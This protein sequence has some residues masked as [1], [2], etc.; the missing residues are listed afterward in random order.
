[1]RV[2]GIIAARMA[3]TRF[4]NKPLVPV[5]GVPMVGHVYHRAARTKG[6]NEVWIAT[7]DQSIIDYA[8]TIG[9]PAVMTRD[10]H[11][12]ATDRI[13]EAVPYIEE[14]TGEQV[15]VVVLVQGDEPML[16]P[17]MLDEL[18]DAM[19]AKKATV[20]NL[21]NPIAE[22]SEFEDANTVKVVCDVEGYALYLSREPIPSRKKFSGAVPMWKQ[23]G[24][25]AFTRDALMEYANLSSTP[26][27]QIE[28][29]DMNRLLEHG[30][31]ILMVPSMLRTT[32]I[33]TPQ[34][35][36][37]VEKLM[38]D[39]ELMKSYPRSALA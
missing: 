10:T 25:I 34:D 19:L 38:E 20:A 22:A 28:S 23:L 24:L 7:C 21:I 9:A 37:R 36:A 32:A 8:G 27:E 1:M 2:V 33:D 14:R 26:L 39:D 16:Q 6:M 3:S 18:I 30:R 4:P 35:L 17:D 5:R 11:E 12:R 29:V 15:D 31:K 13:A